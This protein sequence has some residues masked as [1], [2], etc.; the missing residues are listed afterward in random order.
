M[1][2][3]PLSASSP[4][5]NSAEIGGGPRGAQILVMIGSAAF[6]GVPVCAAPFPAL[7]SRHDRCRGGAD[8]AETLLSRRVWFLVAAH[9]FSDTPSF[10]WIWWRPCFPG[11]GFHISRSQSRR[12]NTSGPNRR[13]SVAIFHEGADGFSIRRFSHLRAPQSTVFVH[14]YRGRCCSVLLPWIC[15]HAKRTEHYRLSF[16]RSSFRWHW[17]TFWSKPSIPRK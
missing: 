16:L 8:S 17:Q 13:C 6:I 4:T 5:T 10:E 9:N 12:A 2:K 14:C 1:S 15:Q 3:L 11:H 7:A